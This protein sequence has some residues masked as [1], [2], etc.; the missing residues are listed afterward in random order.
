LSLYAMTVARSGWLAS[1]ELSCAELR[2]AE[3]NRWRGR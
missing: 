2:Y 3:L 1:A